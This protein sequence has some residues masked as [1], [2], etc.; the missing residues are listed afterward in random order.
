MQLW[1]IAECGNASARNSRVLVRQCSSRTRVFDRTRG[2]RRRCRS[3][4]LALQIRAKT[5]TND[6]QIS[7]A[8]LHKK[9]RLVFAPWGGSF[10]PSNICLKHCNFCFTYPNVA[11]FNIFR[12]RIFKPSKR[13]FF[14]PAIRHV[15]GV[16]KSFSRLN[17]VHFRVGTSSCF[18]SMFCP[19]HF[20]SGER[21]IFF[22]PF[23]F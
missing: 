13:A 11:G 7:H 19:V 21:F 14:F 6:R 20:L 17:P 23:I 12:W 16:E 4:S 1:L 8:G 22:A 15:W 18:I 10:W 3:A 5:G 9:C 2:A